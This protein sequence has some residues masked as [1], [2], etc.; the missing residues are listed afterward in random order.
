MNDDDHE[1]R[2]TAE[3]L[4]TTVDPLT[5]RCGGMD[6]SANKDRPSSNLLRRTAAT[7][8][9]E[10]VVDDDDDDNRACGE[11]ISSTSNSGSCRKRSHDQT[12]E[13]SPNGK[14][15]ARATGN[16]KLWVD[17]QTP[18]GISRLRCVFR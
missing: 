16:T 8:A 2:V 17:C 7:P 4:P 5:E 18:V 11:S 10:V 12:D 1:D 3:L 13:Q 9:R 6:M 15:L 14:E